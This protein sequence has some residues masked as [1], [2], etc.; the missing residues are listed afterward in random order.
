M[1]AIAAAKGAHLHRRHQQASFEH[2]DRSRDDNRPAAGAVRAGAYTRARFLHRPVYQHKTA[3]GRQAIAAALSDQVEALGQQ[4]P[5]LTII[6]ELERPRRS[7]ISRDDYRV[8]VPSYPV[9]IR[10]SP[11]LLGPWR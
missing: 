6:P 8:M 9:L 10:E 4:H 1:L 7:L 3:A 5:D 11:L 2:R